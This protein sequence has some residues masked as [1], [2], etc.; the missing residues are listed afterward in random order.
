MFCISNLKWK[1]ANILR[2]GMF[3]PEQQVEPT[4]AGDWSQH[5][6]LKMRRTH[7]QTAQVETGTLYQFILTTDEKPTAVYP[8]PD[9]ISVRYFNWDRIHYSWHHIPESHLGW[10]IYSRIFLL[11]GTLTHPDLKLI[12]RTQNCKIPGHTAYFEVIHKTAKFLGIQCT[13]LTLKSCIYSF[14]VRNSWAFNTRAW[15]AHTTPRYSWVYI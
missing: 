15:N 4:G 5:A 13:G 6:G 1:N 3:R 2:S 11:P 8:I 7:L 12:S 14:M 9:E 10:N